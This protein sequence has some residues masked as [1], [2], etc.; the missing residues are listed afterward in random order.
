MLGCDATG[1]SEND[2]PVDGDGEDD[3]EVGVGAGGED[4]DGLGVGLMVG[5]EVGLSGGSDAGEEAGEGVCDMMGAGDGAWDTD[6]VTRAKEMARRCVAR[7]SAI[8]AEG[9]KRKWLRRETEQKRAM[10]VLFC[11]GYIDK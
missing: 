4:I 8:V 6:I 1:I 7:V 5:L 11:D 10:E 2:S 3:G 9:R